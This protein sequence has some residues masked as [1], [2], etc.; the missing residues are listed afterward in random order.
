M[1]RNVN[2]IGHLPNYLHEYDEIKNIMDAENPEFQTGWDD[3]TVVEDNS[4]IIYTNEDGI[5]RF[6]KM[7]GITP[8][9]SDNLEAR[10]SR[11]IS[12][13]NDGIPYTYKG[14]IQKLTTLCGEGNFTVTPDFNNYGLDVETS[15][16]LSS[17]V[18]EL[19]RLLSYMIPANIVVT[20]RNELIRTVSVKGYTANAV[21][22]TRHHEI[23]TQHNSE[24][25]MTTTLGNAFVMATTRHHEINCA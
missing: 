6:E 13:W 21:A 9:E 3:T 15:L 2:L 16:S 11:V 23:N 20:S 14:F 22:T 25:T 24:H 8:E 1:Y 4:F 7:M 17:Q 12:R 19:D 18:A 10:K 5:S